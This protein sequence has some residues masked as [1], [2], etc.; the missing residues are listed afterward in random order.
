VRFVGLFSGIGGLEK[1]FENAGFETVMMSEVDPYCRAVLRERF[2]KQQIFGDIMQL[3]TLP[4]AEAVVAGFPCQP[5]SQAGPMQGL[6]ASRQLLRKVI[7]LVEKSRPRPKYV[8]LEN[9]KNIIHLDGGAALAYITREFERLK[10]SWAYRVV[11]SSAFGLP[12]RRKRWLFVATRNNDAAALLLC[13]DYKPHK[14][15]KPGAHGFYWTEGNTGIGWAN[16]A[17]PP[18]KGGSG[19]GIPSPP[20][21]W[22]RETNEIA[23]PSLADAERLQGFDAGWTAMDEREPRYERL[24]WRMIGNAVSVPMAEWLAR[25]IASSNSEAEPAGPT[26]LKSGPWPQAAWGRKGVRRAIHVGSFPTPIAHEPLLDFLRHDLEPLSARA[27][28]GFRTRLEQ[29]SL[30]YERSFLSALKMHERAV[31]R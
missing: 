30:R 18:L 31:S 29:S 23:T 28:L 5:Y 14:V 24:R 7:A 26:F 12:Q 1:G 11:D 15:E 10:Y 27:T 22:I 20:A 17:V 21:I 6:D 13:D 8:V 2:P 19:L 3:R 9:V 4:R 25:S 16:D